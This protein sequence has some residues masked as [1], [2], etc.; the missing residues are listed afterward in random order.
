MLARR[1]TNNPNEL[2]PAII[3]FSTGTALLGIYFPVLGMHGVVAPTQRWIVAAQ[4][5]TFQAIALIEAA[6][7]LGAGALLLLTPRW[8]RLATTGEIA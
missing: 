1:C 8:V 4:F 7:Y 2:A 5:E 6:V 3:K